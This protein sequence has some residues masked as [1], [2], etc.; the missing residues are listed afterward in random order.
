[1]NDPPA[2]DNVARFERAF[3]AFTKGDMETALEHIDPSFEVDDRVAPEAN[4][5]ERG[6]EALIANSAQVYEAFGEISWEPVEI[7]DLGDR[8]LVR[9]RM[10]AVGRATS[11]PIDEDVGHL[12]TMEGIKAVKLVIYRTW[13]EAREAAGLPV[14]S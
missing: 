1:M 6:P 8:V 3:D 4:P 9:V 13:D 7:V 14:D 2:D 10:T 11:L 5:S 12:Y